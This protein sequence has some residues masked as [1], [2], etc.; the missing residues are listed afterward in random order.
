MSEILEAAIQVTT[1]AKGKKKQASVILPTRK[2][3]TAFLLTPSTLSK[4]L[5]AQLARDPQ[6]N[7]MKVQVEREAGQV[8]RVWQVGHEWE[9][10]ASL[11]PKRAPHHQPNHG[12]GAHGHQGG[13]GGHGHAVPQSQGATARGNRAV[14]FENPYNFVP[15]P[16]R[17]D[18]NQSDLG[19]HAPKGHHRYHEDHWSGRISVCL[20][21]KPLLLIP[22]AANLDRDPDTKHNTYRMRRSPDGS[23]Y[24]PPTS[25][26][27]MLRSAYEA[28][29]NSRMGVVD[30]RN[31]LLP[32][33][34]NP[35][36][37]LQLVSVRIEQVGGALQ[38][39]LLPGPTSIDP[40]GRPAV[41]RND[42]V[43]GRP[44]QV[45]LMY[46]AWLGRYK[47]YRR[48]DI[49]VLDKE[50]ASQSKKYAGGGGIPAHQDYVHVRISQRSHGY[51]DYSKVDEIRAASPGTPAPTG[52]H[53]G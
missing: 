49:P 48:T 24:L 21:T 18:T 28:V 13:R 34:M 27:G 4:E 53:A 25:I 15:A 20:T 3:T 37:G 42:T 44:V 33:R 40:D 5:A 17:T 10:A 11:P 38:A 50:E 14:G 9:A 31:E 8:K 19:D 26:K 46:A 36:E 12:P 29:T 47:K 7:G 35:K 43:N 16:P 39:R 6:L 32:F 52:W 30:K 2:G 41:I 51:F 45:R 1:V 23:P 22:D